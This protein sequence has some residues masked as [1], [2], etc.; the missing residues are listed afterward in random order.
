[1]RG[2]IDRGAAMRN[3]RKAAG[4]GRERLAEKAGVTA[5]T[6]WNWEHNISVPS[7]DALLL[8]TETLGVSLDAY[9]GNAVLPDGALAPVAHWVELACFPRDPN[10][11]AL[12]IPVVYMCSRCGR[13]QYEKT[14]VCMCG[15]R[16]DGGVDV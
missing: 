14:A 5:K 1:M 13:L 9:V 7:M 8:V 6:L 2:R 10:A 11:S 15:L 16:M 12:V 4:I 3:C